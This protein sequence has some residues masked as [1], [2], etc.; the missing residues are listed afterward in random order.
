M[1]LLFGFG[2]ILWCRMTATA[3]IFLK[4]KFAWSECFPVIG[5]STMYQLGFAFSGAM[6]STPIGGIDYLAVVIFI[7]GSGVNTGSE[8][9]R[10]QFKKDPQNKGKLYTQGLFGIVRHPNYLGDILWATGWAILTQ[11]YWASII[12]VVCAAGFIFMFIPQLSDYLADHYGKQ[13]QEWEKRSKKLIP[14][15]Y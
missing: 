3:F 15:V 13:Y 5:A 14:M 10:K 6:I 4:R 9:Q 8:W 11:N 7:L 12:P 2:V 1:I